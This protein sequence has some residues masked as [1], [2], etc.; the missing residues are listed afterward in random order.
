M[1][2]ESEPMDA[3]DAEAQLEEPAVP[4]IPVEPVFTVTDVREKRENRRKYLIKMLIVFNQERIPGSGTRVLTKFLQDTTV[5][6][7]CINEPIPK[8]VE[9]L[10]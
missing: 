4:L 10:S 3:H 1:S 9:N 7:K 8:E 2:E 6:R 5:Q